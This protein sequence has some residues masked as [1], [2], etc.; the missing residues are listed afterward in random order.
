MYRFMY[1]ALYS[2]LVPLS[3]DLIVICRRLWPLM[4]AASIV[5]CFH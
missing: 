1:Q 4:V 2:M 5:S 3:S